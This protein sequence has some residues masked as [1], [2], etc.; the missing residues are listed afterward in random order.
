MFHLLL[1]L[2]VI[3]NLISYEKRPNINYVQTRKRVWHE[4]QET[5][6]SESEYRQDLTMPQ[7]WHMRVAYFGVKKKRH[8]LW[9]TP[10]GITLKSKILVNKHHYV[11]FRQMTTS[12]KDIQEF[13][14]I[15][16]QMT[17]ELHEQMK[18]E[19][20][21]QPITI[22]DQQTI[23]TLLT[24]HY[25]EVQAYM[26]V[27][28]TDIT[29]HSLLTLRPQKQLNDEV[30]N[31]FFKLLQ[32]KETQST[33]MNT[34]FYTKLTDHGHTNKY[35]YINVR[36][37]SKNYPNKNLFNS[38]YLYIPIHVDDIHW[39]LVHVDFPNK[40]VS[41][42]DSLGYNGD[43]VLNNIMNYIQ[44]EANK[45]NLTNNTNEWTLTNISNSIPA[46]ENNNTDCG[47]FIIIYAYYLTKKYEMNFTQCHINDFRLRIVRSILTSTV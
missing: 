24:Q 31:S 40:K 35:C 39:S 17:D 4:I 37:W 8:I 46:Q 33:Y 19:P 43:D 38:T 36:N 27:P 5:I 7:N 30:I 28:E 16:K 10:Q 12:P 23:N 20:F 21:V 44:D 15:N 9:R 13:I 14:N 11:Q 26:V 3:H 45:L 1:T 32:Q 47:V 29:L 2:H 6:S 42:L 34:Y 22:I 41:Y 25:D 18:L